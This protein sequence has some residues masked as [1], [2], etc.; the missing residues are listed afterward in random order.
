MQYTFIGPRSRTA[1]TVVVTPTN[2]NVYARLIDVFR[3]LDDQDFVDA[4][5]AMPQARA[6]L[7]S[8]YIALL[9]AVARHT[10]SLLLAHLGRHAEGAEDVPLGVRVTF[11]SIIRALMVAK[12]ELSTSEWPCFLTIVAADAQS[13]IGRVLFQ[14][15]NSTDRPPNLAKG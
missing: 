10:N 8:D 5:G 4:T 7:L 11:N 13:R 1:I 14:S 2:E 6:H 3:P 12:E 9:G 15:I